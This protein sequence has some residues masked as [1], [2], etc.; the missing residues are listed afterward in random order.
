MAAAPGTTAPA[1]S[2]AGS[3]D[4]QTGTAAGQA[5]AGPQSVVPFLRGSGKGK[6]RFYSKSLTLTAATQDLGPI[7]VKAYDYIRSIL[8]VCTNTATGGATGTAQ[9]DAPFNLFTNVAVK[10]P[11]GQT[12]YQVSSGYHGAMISKYG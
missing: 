5:P 1:P 12:M 8:I 4:T 6:Y 7:D 3:A 11:N 10:Q 9:G 2:A